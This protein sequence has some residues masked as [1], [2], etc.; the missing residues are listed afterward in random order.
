MTEIN[1]SKT[2]KIISIILLIIMLALLID[3]I[4]IYN[5]Y[6]IWKPDAMYVNKY[7]RSGIEAIVLITL[8]YALL[9]IKASKGK[10]LLYKEEF[11][12]KF[13]FKRY[14]IISSIII[15]VLEM[16]FWILRIIKNA[17]LEP[18][19]FPHFLIFFLLTVF[20]YMI[21]CDVLMLSFYLSYVIA[22]R[23]LDKTSAL[24]AN[25]N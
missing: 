4:L 5:I 10:L 3:I 16:A 12:D 15:L 19:G 22:K 2:L 20:G 11:P 14:L 9:F 25:D 23:K 24:Q 21:I 8:F 17:K 6:Y 7:I 18:M 1:K 13:P